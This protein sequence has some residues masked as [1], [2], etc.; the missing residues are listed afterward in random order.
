M[1]EAAVAARQGKTATGSRAEMVSRLMR[2]RSAAIVGMSSRPGS[3]G[4]VALANLTQNK[5]AGDIH[6]VGRGGGEVDGR[7]VLTSVDQLPEGIDLAIVV[8][9]AAATAEAVEGL[10][11][12]KV[13]GAVSFAAGFA[14]LNDAGAA[15]QAKIE[16]VVR[17][18]GIALV[19]PNCLGYTNY[20]DGFAVGL[21]GGGVVPRLDPKAGRAIGVI[22]QSG[23]LIGHFRLAYEARHLPVSYQV[24]TGNEVGLTVADFVD[25]L[26]TD[27]ATGTIVIYAEDI[28]R[29]A[30]FLA[31]ARRAREAGKPIVMMHPGR[32]AKAQAAAHSHTGALAGDYAAMRTVVEHAGVCLVDT[33][34]EMVDV[35]ELLTRF[36]KPPT[37]G[38]GIV[39]YSG[40]F[41]GIA[42]DFAED[43]GVDIPPLTAKTVDW[44][45]P[46]IPAWATV[47]N[48][49]D[50]TTQP[51]WQPEL[52]GIGTEA[53]LKDD[54]VGSV[55]IS[56][57]IGPTAT[58]LQYLDGL[59]PRI[60]GTEKPISFVAL[61]DGS[62]MLPEFLERVGKAPLAWGRSS[63]RAL[64]ATA[65]ITKLG[66]RWAATPAQAE[67]APFAGLP[68][69]G[70]GTL[71]EV[72]GKA[73]L[74]AIGVSVPDG[75]MATSA[76]AAAAIAKKIGYPVVL[77]AQAAALAHKT[78]AGGVIVNI[79]DEA[80]LRRAWDDL[81]ARV[82]K[83][84]PDVTLDGALV[85]AMAK[86]GLELAIGAKRDPRWGP[87]V[88]VGLGGIWIEA[89]GDVR[90]IPADLPAAAIEAE[91]RKLKAAKLLAGFRGAPPVDVKAV[92]ETAA[93]LGRLMLTRPE[94]TEIDINPLI[95]YPEGQGAT[96]LDALIV[97]G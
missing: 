66:R 42:H 4:H 5:F 40:A 68:T 91:L 23:G 15:E 3:V 56:I 95:A 86:S 82:K 53:V 77:K 52:L 57:S 12:R 51:A 36:P 80:A 21:F 70:K 84:R 37:K 72:E 75:A 35:G 25:F 34:E 19:G 85:E 20:R 44:L 96:A 81:Y 83:A 94:I 90:L 27:D 97:T 55:V 50:L 6:L 8:L 74:K 54:N 22:G 67:P 60:E 10:A 43:L 29:P 18:T 17:E 2:P 62:P 93:K 47:N 65:I 73:V 79:A 1:A 11:R 48:P 64:R 31:A 63:E 14:E 45:K 33:L 69:L 59:L 89:L 26:V 71:A 38:L 49:L 92:A 87:I 46:Q 61:G 39:T 28:H 9:P 58:A 78:E 88:M 24:T 13:A 41:C 30:E 32:S 16:K 7:K 76:D